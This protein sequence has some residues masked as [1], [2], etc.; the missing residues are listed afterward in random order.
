MKNTLSM[1]TANA[2]VASARYSPCSRSAGRAT[3]AP[4]GTAT[5]DRGEQPDGRAVGRDLH[6]GEGAQPGEGHLAQGHL[7]GPAGQRDQRQ[8]DQPEGQPGATFE[9]VASLVTAAKAPATATSAAAATRER[10]RLASGGHAGARRSSRPRSRTS[11][12]TQQDDE[13]HQGRDGQADVG[14][15]A[16]GGQVAD[17]VRLGEAEHHRADERERHA[18]QAADH[19]GGVGVHDQQA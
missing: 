1:S 5:D 9:R 14:E 15:G 3:S 18:A 8:R 11:G 16:V 10:G 4:T 2:R 7:T 12:I 6:H 17:R 19:G 13:E